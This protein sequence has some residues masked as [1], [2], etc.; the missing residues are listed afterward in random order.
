MKPN[1]FEISTKELTQYA[2][3]VW[4]LKW[5][6][7]DNAS[8]N[9]ELNICGKDFTHSLIKKVYPDFSDAIVTVKAGRQLNYIDIWAIVNDKYFIIIEDKTET[10]KHGNQLSNYKKWAEKHYALYRPVLIFLK[11]GNESLTRL[12][13]IEEKEGYKWFSRQEFLDILKKYTIQND[14]YMDYLFHL[15]R[16]EQE[17]QSYQTKKGL[18]LHGL[19]PKG[20]FCFCRV[21]SKNILIG[22]MYQTN[23]ADLWGSFITGGNIKRP[24]RN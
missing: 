16:I 8:E 23:Q 22:R 17:T 4:L 15:Q 18:E 20:F 12:F 7:E 6:D 11:T 24:G 5:A 1:L 9:T 21:I 2:F 3:I 19:V 10:T 14:I 13:S